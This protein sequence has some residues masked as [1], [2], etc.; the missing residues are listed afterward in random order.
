MEGRSCDC[1][2]SG[3]VGEEEASCCLSLGL[4]LWQLEVR[5][6]RRRVGVGCKQFVGESGAHS[7]QIERAERHVIASRVKK[8]RVF[9]S[10]GY[11]ECVRPRGTK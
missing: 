5:V 1:A 11:L 4:L 8:R 6:V 7:I 3:K 2:G 10:R 9:V